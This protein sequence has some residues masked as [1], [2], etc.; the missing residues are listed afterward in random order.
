M[1][2]IRIDFYRYRLRKGRA[3]ILLQRVEEDGGYCIPYRYVKEDEEIAWFIK[4][5]RIDD[6]PNHDLVIIDCTLNDC[7]LKKDDK[8]WIPMERVAELILLRNDSFRTVKS[9]LQLF[10]SLC[11][12]DNESQ[13]IRQKVMGMLNTIRISIAKKKYI[14]KLQWA[15]DKEHWVVPDCSYTVTNPELIK[16]EMETLEHFRL[17]KSPDSEEYSYEPIEWEILGVEEKYF[18]SLG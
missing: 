11:P 4:N 16:H 2:N 1:K 3:E 17:D 14:E 15:L 8:E 5:H 13:M 10:I 18:Y 6:D 7:H 9:I 12:E